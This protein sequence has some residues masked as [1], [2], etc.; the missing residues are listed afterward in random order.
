MEL[1]S[2][3][4]CQV[5]SRTKAS[6]KLCS[7]LLAWVCLLAALDV[8][9]AFGG[10]LAAFRPA[11]R[12]VKESTSSITRLSANR[13]A[14]SGWGFGRIIGAA[15]GYDT[16]SP[17]RGQT[18]ERG[19]AKRS[20]SGE[21]I[22][23]ILLEDADYAS[24]L[25]RG[26]ISEYEGVGPPPAPSR[27]GKR[28]R[29]VARRMSGNA[30]VGGETSDDDM[31][32]DVIDA[33]A[34]PASLAELKKDLLVAC[35]DSNRGFGGSMEQRDAV[36]NIVTLVRSFHATFSLFWR[37]KGVESFVVRG[38]VVGAFHFVFFALSIGIGLICVF[39]CVILCAF[40]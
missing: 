28:Q 19:L 4:C 21:A 14:E 34:R 15:G 16:G 33:E 20:A 25:F 31:D 2:Y 40:I 18:V 29:R 38:A 17:R 7:G 5:P 3:D 24:V 26:M 32:D 22:E 13:E 1:D 30:N 39:A 10:Q 36:V 11:L 27:R 6:M 9:G 8:A 12:C 23:Q 35:A 37:K